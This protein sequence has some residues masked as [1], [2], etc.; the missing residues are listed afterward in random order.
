M[1]ALFANRSIARRL[2]LGV[3]IATALV[4]GLAVWFNH[5]TSR[6]QLETQT[7]LKAVSQIRA[8]ARRLDDFI[9]RIGMLP[10]GIAVRQQ[11]FGRDPDPGMVPHLRELLRETPSEEVYGLYIAY[12]HMDWRDPNSVPGSIARPG[13][14]S[15]R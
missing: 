10:H 2:Q 14:T 12:E 9:A 4:L 1:K 6:E 11:A 13:R 3:G 15:R 7:N 8:A 5:R